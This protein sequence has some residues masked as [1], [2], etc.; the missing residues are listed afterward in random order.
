MFLPATNS[1]RIFR[2]L[3]CGLLAALAAQ[4]N[5]INW[6]YLEGPFGGRVIAL[7]HD[8][9]GNTW[10]G[11]LD[12]RIYYRAAGTRTW[13]YRGESPTPIYFWSPSFGD[14]RAGFAFDSAGNVYLTS[15]ASGL[16]SL[17][18]GATTWTRVSGTNGLPE[19]V[20]GALAT[21]AAGT[22]YAAIDLSV[23]KLVNGGTLWTL[24]GGSTP[25]P[26]C[27]VASLA[28]D[29][30]G[31][32]WATIGRFGAYKL[33]PGSDTWVLVDAGLFDPRIENLIAVGSDLFGANHVGVF[34]LANAAGGATTWV[35]W[36]GGDMR[37][38]YAVYALARGADNALY[39]AGYRSVY[40][41]PT[42]SS[43]W[44]KL[45]TGL[46][47]YFNSFSLVHSS[48][49][50]SLTLGN[51]YGVFVLPAGGSTWEAQVAGMTSGFAGGLLVAPN[52]DVYATGLGVQRQAAGTT[53]WSA[54]DPAHV[55]PFAGALTIDRHGTIFAVDAGRVV[56]LVNGSW[57][58][59]GDGQNGCA[60]TLHV[61]AFDALWAACYFWYVN[62]YGTGELR[63]QK[64]A[65]GASTWVS[66]GA[67]GPVY[68]PG[69]TNVIVDGAGTAYVG[70]HTLGYVGSDPFGI[71]A[72][73][74]GATTW[75]LN[76]AGLGSLDVLALQRDADGAVYA[77]T[78]DG[79][80][81]R[82]AGIWQKVG[83]GLDT[84]VT[85]LAIDTNGD[86][87]ADTWRLAAGTS[88]W[89]SIQ[90]GLNGSIKTLA[91]GGGRIYAGTGAYD[92]LGG[93]PSG[94]YILSMNDSVFELHNDLLDHF[95]ITASAAEKDAVLGGSAGPGWA[96]TGNVFSAGGTA[97]VCRFHG[98]IAP[99]PNSHFYTIDPAE[100]QS[101]KD[102]QA[103]TPASEKRWNFE[104]YDFASTP[105]VA[106]QCPANTI[107]VYR[108][109]N[110]GFARGIDSNHRITSSRNAYLLQVAKGW[111]GEGVAMCAPQ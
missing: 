72:L 107:A 22:V 27:C 81:K 34:K 111:I 3:L 87:Y 24:V 83:T 25:H 35:P 19:G 8:A 48:L 103:I 105:P 7:A 59:A 49:D 36:M 31:N 70:S 104:G 54:V 17:A 73:A 52:G 39:A 43:A 82:V 32:A 5:A 109:Y 16:Y 97:A 40:T 2:W 10:A 58:T 92:G 79:V 33:A 41:V 13:V 84:Y 44:T 101:L 53:T 78:G 93:S 62:V 18:A 60:A 68:E 21:D 85:A 65:S 94:V 37:A 99:G 63:V 23:Y 95:F 80:Y 96:L 76:N 38:G 14:P 106:G 110:N 88:T 11:S 98:S 4:A 30:A 9:A 64:L 86:L 69:I 77:A 91:L 29:D 28:I 50:G 90:L 100:C 57:M 108:A 51:D 75:T 102:L 47:P 20:V 56:K 15:G 1:S 66:A 67:V 42:G 26:P 6:N 89:T 74:P 71:Y 12:S 55:T 46:E 45:G 61:D